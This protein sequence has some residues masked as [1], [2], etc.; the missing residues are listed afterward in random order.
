MFDLAT[1]HRQLAL[2]LVLAVGLLAL[3][4][5]SVSNGMELF[6]HP[7]A[8]E[9]GLGAPEMN[10][11][12]CRACH[13]DPVMGG[14][15]PLELNVTRFG[16][17]GG[18]FG[19]FVDLPGGQLLSKLRPPQTAGREE[20]PL[21]PIPADVFEQRQTPSILGDG[22]ID[23][24]PDAVILANEDPTDANSDGIF[25][26]ARRRTINGM[27]E[28]GR[29]GWK[30]QVPR[31]ADFVNDAM[32]GELGMTTPD[33][34]RPFAML[35]DADGIADPEI[36]QAQVDDIAAF[37]AQL[38]APVRGGSTDPRVALGEQV[39]QNIGCAVCHIPSLAGASGPVPL[40]SN[41]LLHDVMPFNYRGM[42]EPGAGVGMFR[43]PPLWGI[44]DTAPYMHDGRAE[45]LKAA[46]LAHSG[47]AATVTLAFQ[48][49]PAAEREALILF[50]ED[51]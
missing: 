39:F 12:S 32:G 37:M 28:I 9:E 21:A 3:Q 4:G 14:A 17:D 30:A 13:R 31:L 47:E 48:L 40:Y 35:S 8:P 24:I 16:N 27:V 1:G 33:N 22:L 6:D 44:K 20:H 45:D 46:I 43:T 10:A 7:F 36:S 5:S 50:L 29:F 34:G 11:D 18:G 51:L 2:G 23:G 26:V 42:A 15:G 38:P 49:R 19:V 41:L 25:G